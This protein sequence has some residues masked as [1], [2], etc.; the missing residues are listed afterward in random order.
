[1]NVKTLYTIIGIVTKNLTVEKI[2]DTRYSSARLTGAM[3]SE[4]ASGWLPVKPHGIS[5]HIQTHV[6]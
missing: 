2:H 3:A 6:S 4:V 1:M 5:G